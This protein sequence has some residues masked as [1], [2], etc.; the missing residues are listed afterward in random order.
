MQRIWLRYRDVF[1]KGLKLSTET[2]QAWINLIEEEMDFYKEGRTYVGPGDI[3]DRLVSDKCWHE[4]GYVH[5]GMV[6]HICKHGESI[7]TVSQA[8]KVFRLICEAQCASC[9]KSF[10]KRFVCRQQLKLYY[11]VLQLTCSG[12]IKI[13]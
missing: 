4:A 9:R 1:L 11:W 5:D 3:G 8:N 12:Y 6:G 10:L 13:R 2:Y 7:F